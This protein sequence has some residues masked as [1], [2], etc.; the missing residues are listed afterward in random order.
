MQ[1]EPGKIVYKVTKIPR[2]GN[3]LLSGE[4]VQQFTQEDINQYR[5]AYKTDNDFLDEWT[6][7]DLFLFKVFINDS[8]DDSVVDEHRFKISITYA[9]LPSHR[10]HEFIQLRTVVVSRG[11]FN[12]LNARSEQ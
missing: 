11:K 12:C 10:L 5:L 6:K 2:Y 9:A 1:A 4:S 8:T 3:L 7:R